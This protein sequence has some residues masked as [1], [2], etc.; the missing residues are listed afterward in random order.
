MKRMSSMST[1]YYR[2][3]I[4]A[5]ALD[6]AIL[7]VSFLAA[8]LGRALL[9]ERDLFSGIYFIAFIT[10]WMIGFMYL[11][12][13]YRRIWSRSSGHEVI[14]IVSAV[15]ATLSVAL[16]SDSLINPRPISLSVIVFGHIFA[17]V[18]FVA[19]RY[20][21]R[22]IYGIKWRW[23][24]VWNRE[25]PRGISR[26]LI[27]GAGEAG[28][29]IAMRIRYRLNDQKHEILGFIDDDADKQGMI[30]EG[31]RVL[32]TRGD[33][34]R[35]A[36]ERQ[37]DLIIV[38]MHNVSGPDFRDILTECEKTKARIKIVPDFY[39]H[40]DSKDR[41]P[42]LRD[43]QPEDLIGRNRI[44]RHEAVDLTPVIS[45]VVLVTG[46][47]GSIGSEL[48]RQI[49]EYTP[50]KVL[51]VDNNESGLH[52]LSIELRAKHP[53]IELVAVLLDITQRERLE[54]LYADHRPALVFHAAA[55]K[56]VPML[57]YFPTEAIRVNVQGTRNVAELA[58]DYGVER[59]VLISTD[60]AVNPSSVMGASKRLCELLLHTL[61]C[62]AS[63]KTL[64][65]SVRFGN[66][67]GSRGSVV[68]TFNQQIENGG[69]VTVTHPEMT[70]Y[71]MSIPEAVNL[72]I[73]AACLTHDD[74]I[75]ILKM[76]EVVRV[77][78]LA[79]RMIRLRGLRPYIDIPIEFTGIRPGEKM[80]EELWDPSENPSDTLHPHII[81]LDTW[82]DDFDADT[83]WHK[84]NAL[85]GDTGAYEKDPLGT[86]RDLIETH[87]PHT[88]PNGTHR[89]ISDQA[90]HGAHGAESPDKVIVNSGD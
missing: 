75:F 2:R 38:A 18:G 80:H 5:A 23:R 78:E 1:G 43:I 27:I 45:R 15:M 16:V 4:K 49:L 67:L 6:V 41:A 64:F 84:L 21:S 74:D 77:V 65:T 35:I 83:Y 68:P 44:S 60:K 8:L 32:G 14:V 40:I 31:C 76:G 22:L 79:E 88:S 61:A 86:M 56:H 50:T 85:I 25:F 9:A 13:V 52:D 29:S 53:K 72:I 24:A 48:S 59:F 63:C 33:I 12:G 34:V 26:V 57:E 37:I 82:S 19:A 73:H 30:I 10:C 20:R 28:Q 69:P 7:W 46:A 54:K 47:A 39:G 66:V 71:F 81:K 11:F 55:Y 89:A 70:R 87:R 51:L 17:L 90:H 42:M 3:F 36:S 62:Q 58:R